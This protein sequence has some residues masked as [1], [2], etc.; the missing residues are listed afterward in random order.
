MKFLSHIGLVYQHQYQV[1]IFTDATSI[2]EVHER[3]RRAEL[4]AN[5]LAYWCRRNGYKNEFYEWKR[6][7]A[8]ILFM[9]AT[10]NNTWLLLKN[11]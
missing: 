5:E 6:L 2:N 11:S 3:L 10:V 1:M 4:W 8:R 7:H 9:R